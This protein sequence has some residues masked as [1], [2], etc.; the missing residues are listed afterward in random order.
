MMVLLAACSSGGNPQATTFDY[1]DQNGR[2][3]SVANAF[4]GQG[5]ATCD[6]PSQPTMACVKSYPVPCWDV[7]ALSDDGGPLELQNCASCCA[8]DGGAAATTPADC[9]FV[10]CQTSDDCPKQ[11]TCSGGVCSLQ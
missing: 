11:F 5:Q 2:Q 7:F 1:S 3:C 9:S 4:V 10:V 6:V 8:I